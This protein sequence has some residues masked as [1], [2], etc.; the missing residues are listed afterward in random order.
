MYADIAT[1]LRLERVH[2]HI[3]RGEVHTDLGGE[4]QDAGPDP[5]SE[6]VWRAVVHVPHG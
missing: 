4:M 1:A 6:T 3:D 5:V 2:I